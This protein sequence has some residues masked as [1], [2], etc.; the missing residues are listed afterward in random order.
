MEKTQARFEEIYASNYSNVIRVCL[1]YVSGDEVLAKELS[2]EVFIKVWENLSS[3]RQ[4]AS[5][6]TWIY[7]ITVNTC[8]LYFRKKKKE[9]TTAITKPIEQT[10]DEGYIRKESQLEKM[11]ACINK[12][13]QE[14]KAIILLE[15][16]GVPQKEI[17]E[18]IGL[19]HEAIRVRIHRIK[20]NL[21]KC[22]QH[23]SI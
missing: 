19:T 4:E 17:A 23:G 7:R 5:V 10:E 6:S 11:Y 3:F 13:P 2:Q 12:L 20:N 21:T 14:Q 22:V 8:L 9:N 16:E 1:G 18:I 15:L